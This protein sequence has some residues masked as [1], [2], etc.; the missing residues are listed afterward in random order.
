MNVLECTIK[1]KKEAQAHYERL[2]GTVAN[3]ELKRL[4]VLLAAA[5][6]EYVDKLVTLKSNVDEFEVKNLIGLDEGSCV[7]KPNID[8][9]HVEECLENDPDAYL[10]VVREEQNTINFFD[11]MSAIAESEQIKGICHLLAEKEREHLEMLENIYFFVEEPR[12]YLE[13][14]E[15]SNLKSL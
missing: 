6:G 8:P 1:M 12:T 13:W 3:G 9:L 11:R 10:H 15:F 4:F 2:A 14:G 7:Y 5:E